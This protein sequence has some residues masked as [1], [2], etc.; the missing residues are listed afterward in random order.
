MSLN[1]IYK[2][3][4]LQIKQS[5]Q[6]VANQIKEGWRKIIMEEI[7]LSYTPETYSRQMNLFNSIEIAPIKKRNGEYKIEIYVRD[8]RHEENYTWDGE[9]S[10]LPEIFGKFAKDGFYGRGGRSIDVTKMTYEE[11]VENEKA[12]QLII[13]YLKSCGFEIE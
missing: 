10:T 8:E 7:Y 13:D 2:E 9:N 1:Q 5:L 12:T 6:E 3:L 11:W 4:D